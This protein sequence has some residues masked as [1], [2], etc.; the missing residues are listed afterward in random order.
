MSQSTY[1][2]QKAPVAKANDGVGGFADLIVCPKCGL[3]VNVLRKCAHCDSRMCLPCFY[4]KAHFEEFSL[5]YSIREGVSDGT[6]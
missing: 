4:Q 6:H 2:K 5:N 3:E 1:E